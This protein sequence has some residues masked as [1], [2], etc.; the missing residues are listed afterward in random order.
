MPLT[1]VHHH[2]AWWWLREQELAVGATIALGALTHVALAPLVAGG[3]I[4]AGCMLTPAD[5][6]TAVPARVTRGA[7]TGEVVHTVPAG[8]PIC[9]RGGGTVIYIVLTIPPGEAGLASAQVGVAKVH[10][11]GTWN[12]GQA[13][14]Y[15]GTQKFVHQ[16]DS[17]DI[18]HVNP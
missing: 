6:G 16:T 17:A 9:T 10:T 11:L 14:S 3:P 5:R 7:G 4:M 15:L 13:Q 2:G 8:A 18:A 1:E 12:T